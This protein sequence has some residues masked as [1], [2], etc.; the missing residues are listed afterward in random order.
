VTLGCCRTSTAAPSSNGSARTTRPGLRPCGPRRTR[1]VA[2][3]PSTTAL[4]T[5]NKIEGCELGLMRGAN[6]V[7]PNLTP[8]EYRVKYEIYPGKTCVNETAEMCRGCL[9]GAGR[10]DR[11]RHRRRAG[12]PPLDLTAAAEHADVRT[13]GCRGRGG[14]RTPEPRHD[15]LLNV[16]RPSSGTDR[17]WERPPAGAGAHPRRTVGNAMLKGERLPSASHR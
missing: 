6:I 12:R 4:A 8:P 15:E 3:I 7:M 14:G 5:L 9:Q 16:F 13:A 1:L 2:A 11:P 10:V 17:G